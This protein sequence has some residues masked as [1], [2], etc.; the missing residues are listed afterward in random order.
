MK[1]VEHI[2]INFPGLLSLHQY[3]I[4]LLFNLLLKHVT[5]VAGEY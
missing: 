3:F 1:V 4:T 2:I 5:S